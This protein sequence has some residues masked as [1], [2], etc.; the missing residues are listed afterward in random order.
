[1]RIIR[2]FTLSVKELTKEEEDRRKQ[3]QGRFQEDLL[4]RLEYKVDIKP[5]KFSTDIG[6][7]LLIENLLTQLYRHNRR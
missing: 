4:K 7:Q 1:M 2:I 3:R 5:N 6:S